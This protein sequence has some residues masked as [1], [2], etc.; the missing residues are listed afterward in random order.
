[1]YLQKLRDHQAG[2]IPPVEIRKSNPEKKF[3]FEDKHSI[4]TRDDLYLL[5]EA[6]R[7]QEI[8]K[9]V[10]DHHLKEV[11]DGHVVNH[12]KTK[13]YRKHFLPEVNARLLGIECPPYIPKSLIVP[14]ELKNFSLT[15]QAVIVEDV[16]S[17]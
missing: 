9:M 3:N 5:D 7:I 4:K 14:D 15:Q 11:K 6:Q 12:I 2:I 16:N 10:I 17:Y 1:M 13:E 8:A